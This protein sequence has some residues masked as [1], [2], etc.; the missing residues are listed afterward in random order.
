MLRL[1]WWQILFDFQDQDKLR[2]LSRLANLAIS[3]T[4][5]QDMDPI[6]TNLPYS[7]NIEEDVP[8]VSVAVSPH[9]TLLIWWNSVAEIFQF[10]SL[11]STSSVPFAPT[12]PTSFNILYK[13]CKM[14]KVKTEVRAVIRAG[15]VRPRAPLCAS[16]APRSLRLRLTSGPYIQHCRC[17]GL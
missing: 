6:F 2:P 9:A 11:H 16:L 10:S 12:S 3:I 15:C 7:T 8:L 5:V 14:I 17:W 13:R 4:D 1:W